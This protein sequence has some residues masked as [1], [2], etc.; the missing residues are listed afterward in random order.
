MLTR[1]FIDRPV[2]AWVISIVIFLMGLIAAGLLPIAQY[3]E[4][5][6][7]T[8]R[9]TTSYPGANA[10][11][12]ADT[13][14]APIEQQVNGVENM[15]YMSS[16]SSNDG[17][18]TL[19]VTFAVGTN[20]NMAQ[21]LV[22]NRVAIAEPMLPDEVKAN[23]VLVKKRSPDLLL[24]INLYSDIDP[25]TG[26]PYFDRLYM[27]NYA[28]I[29]LQDVLARVEGVGD[30][31]F[32]GQKEYSMR[33]WLDPYKL[34]S[35]NLTAND[36]VKV[37]Q[38]QNVQVAAGQIGQPP[39]PKG[40]D[41]QYTMTALGRLVEPE[42]FANIIIKTGNDGE[43]VYLK[44]VAR[45]E[46]GA[47]N[48]DQGCTLDGKPSTGVVI[49]QLPGTNALDLADR[50]K[51][52]MRE[53]ATR[54]P[55]GLRYAIVVDTTPFIRESV[56]EVF[57]TLRDAVLL[58]A[59]VVLLFLQD[60]RSLLLPVIDVGVSLVGTFAVMMLM[61]FSLNNLTLFG[62][63]LA[64]GIVV[65]DAIVVLE[66][67]ERWLDKGLPV[68]EATIKAMDEITGPI[69]AI[70]LVLSSVFLPSAFLGGITGQF[71]RQF[72]LTISVS[73][74]ISAINAMT[75]TPARA[76]SI[77]ANRKP[78]HHGEQGKEAFPWWGFALLGGLVSV[79]L[80]TPTLG[81][82]LGLPAGE[83]G[84]EGR[85]SDLLTTLLT[86]G[87]TIILFLPGALAGGILGRWIIGGVNRAA[88]VFF[89]GFNWVFDRTTQVY[90][91]TVGRALRLSVVMLLLFLG[92]IGL[93][94]Y[95]FTQI[96]SGFI[97]AQDK[98]RLY[99]NVQLADSAALEHTE[100]VM[101]DIQK[102]LDHMDG[103][104]HTTAVPG[105]S[106]VLN[107]IS[108]NMGSMFVTL[109]PFHD[110][111][112]PTLSSDAIAETLRQRLRR[113]IPDARIN[114][115]GVP[116]VDGLGT[117]GGFKIMVEA[118]GDVNF[119]ALQAQANNLAE[120]GNQ[121]PG[122][123]GLFCGF[124]ANTPQLFVDVDRTKCKAM[125]VPLTDVFLTLQVFMGGYYAN[126]FNRFG[127]T[128]QVNIQADDSFRMDADTV[129]QLKVRNAD[130]DMVP[131]GSVVDF[132]DSTG[133][134]MVTRYNMFPTA[135][136]NGASLPGVSSGAVMEIMEEL[137][138]KE[139]PRSMTYEWTD[140]GYFQKQASKVGSFKDLQQNPFSAFV[141][142]VILVFFVLAGL[143]ESWSLPLAVIL[144]VPMCL[145]SALAG[146][147]LARMD[148][149]IFVQVA[150]VVLVG[151]A[152]KNA[153][154]IVEFA[155]D[156]QKGGAS[157]FEAAVEAARVRLRP[158]LMTSFAFILGV[159]PLVIAH[160][161]GA[162]MRR[163][164][165]TA[166]FAGMLGV[167]LFGIFL[168]PVF[169]YVIRR[170]TGQGKAQG[171]RGKPDGWDG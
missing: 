118:T 34:A 134:T 38:E 140:L 68:R 55:R 1:F 155:R 15:L 159:L 69:L 112:D 117:A 13:V 142:G 59:F 129:K 32:F 6:P 53:L 45:T 141:L 36:V 25:E 161:A 73:M 99:V 40:Q 3:P 86:W 4:I 7:P 22:Q 133:P 52:K 78:G 43:V 169:F 79:W 49:F 72:A 113:D 75:M 46:L 145:S 93:T 77:F 47:R 51:A 60:W 121:K 66:N 114:V 94:G 28:T 153:I 42:Q 41:F 120:K 87:I 127:R 125:N 92:V 135:A 160:G 44:D 16:Q 63:V 151:L 101:A 170:L 83:E 85:V 58:V 103:V 8:I 149:N 95:G 136:I 122:L 138:S 11:V 124:R 119:S 166:V 128:W 107:A 2:L 131:L 110:R 48:Q 26:L 24:V 31:F 91:K 54:F 67:I 35:W 12:V 147:F 163:T 98:G 156:R 146:V 88:N 148:V 132:R 164:L 17:S 80:L 19:D 108:S 116:A 150:F 167:T 84:G 157:V 154:L 20:M 158:I 14:A 100:A 144:V 139:L 23:G 105:R 29:Q 65:D 90:G 50:V 97:P 33:V 96:P 102:I 18:Y 61:G 111:R 89:H 10:Q 82:A 168:T 165:G 70:T 64:I 27:S 104:A 9:V 74:V 76:A 143:Y 37:L 21:V 130:G 71:F 57:H 162:E 30:I 152:A 106:F 115:F 137:A 56:Q 171:S 123:V 109:K 62:L 5:T 81:V 39:I 126:D